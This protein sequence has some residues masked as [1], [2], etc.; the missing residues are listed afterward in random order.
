MDY[1]QGCDLEVLLAEQPGPSFP[2]PLVLM[3]PI[4][5]ALLYLHAQDP[6][7]PSPPRR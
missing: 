3:A 2:L 4:A 1:I 7:V 6:Y 5:D